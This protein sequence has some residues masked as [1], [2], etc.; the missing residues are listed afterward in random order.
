MN[1]ALTIMIAIYGKNLTE[2]SSL[3]HEAVSMSTVGESVCGVAD[4]PL[5]RYAFSKTVLI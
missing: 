1:R 3:G 2:G 4:A 5:V